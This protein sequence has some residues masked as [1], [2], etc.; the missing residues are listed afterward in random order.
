MLEMKSIVSKI[1]KNFEISVKDENADPTLV[2]ELILR[3]KDG[4]VLS[5][6][7]RK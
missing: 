6:K 1:V 7:P 5:F 4:I 2:V 3:P